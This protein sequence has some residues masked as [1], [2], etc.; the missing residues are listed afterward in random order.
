MLELSRFVT[1]RRYFGILPI[2]VFP[3]LHELSPLFLQDLVAVGYPPGREFSQ[4]FP[5]KLLLMFFLLFSLLFLLLLLFSPPRLLSLTSI[6]I[7]AVRGN[8]LRELDVCFL[9]LTFLSIGAPSMDG[10]YAILL[11]LLLS[12]FFQLQIVSSTWTC[13]SSVLIFL[14]TRWEW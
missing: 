7:Y 8:S 11:P 5:Q 2:C 10:V 3:S 12:P 1:V 13:L 14:T 6:G 4:E 9:S